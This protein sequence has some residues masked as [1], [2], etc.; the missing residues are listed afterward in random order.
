TARVELTGKKRGKSIVEGGVTAA[1]RSVG[2]LG[3]MMT[4]AVLHGYRQEGLNP[5][6]GIGMPADKRRQFRLEREG[7][8]QLAGMINAA[9]TKGE[10]WQAIGIARLLALTGCR[11]NEIASLKW[12]EVDSAGRCL[13]FEEGRVKSGQLRPIGQTALDLLREIKESPR[14]R[15]HASAYVFPGIGGDKPYQGFAKAWKRMRAA[16]SPHHLRHAFASAAEDDCELHESTV[17]VLLGHSKG[18]NVTRGYIQKADA[19]LLAA[20]DKVSDFIARAMKGE[21]TV[22]PFEARKTG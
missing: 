6:H 8:R 18:G 3:G 4:Y 2:L 14:P 1:K 13:K 19:T 15:Q 16:Y 17:G 5:A 22:I 10:C 20:A 9:E 7:W 21:T 11:L 12:S